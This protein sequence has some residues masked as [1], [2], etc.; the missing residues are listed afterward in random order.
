MPLD[1]RKPNRW[2]APCFNHTVT[3]V[4]TAGLPHPLHRYMPN[5]ECV[6]R[7]FLVFVICI[8]TV[9]W[10]GIS[11]CH[12]ISPATTFVRMASVRRT[13]DDATEAASS[14]I[15]YAGQ[16]RCEE[17]QRHGSRQG[18]AGELLF[19]TLCTLQT[20][21]RP[22]RIAFTPFSPAPQEPGPP[23]CPGSE[24]RRIVR[25]RAEQKSPQPTRSYRGRR[26][27]HCGLPRQRPCDALTGN[28]TFVDAGI[29]SSISIERG[30]QAVE[31]PGAT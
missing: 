6:P 22:E 20:E 24:V 13:V 3:W 7:I 12:R 5:G 27:R 28:V 4:E 10:H 25:T 14:M 9:P 26:G 31:G 23:R 8:R 18:R 19:Y 1:V 29:T 15:Y 17:I 11:P 21:L 16:T 30:M 2:S